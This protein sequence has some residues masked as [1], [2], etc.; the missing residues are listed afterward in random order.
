MPQSTDIPVQL[1]RRE[2]AILRKWNA[3]PD[4][5]DQLAAIAPKVDV[6]TIQLTRVDL[7]WLIG[8][9]NHALVKLGCH[10]EA[11]YDLCERL[12]FILET[13]DGTLQAWY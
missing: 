11:A 2:R 1:R 8:D 13:G 10:D 9:L 12:E 6:A 4:V 3:T 5:Q 7:D